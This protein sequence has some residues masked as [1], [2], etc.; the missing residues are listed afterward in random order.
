MGMFDY[1]QCKHKLS[2]KY[3]P[4]RWFQ[5]KDLDLTLAE[6]QISKEGR[7]LKM[8]TKH[9]TVPVKKRRYY[10]K[11]CREKDH[12]NRALLLLIGSVKVTKLG[13]ED[14]HYHGSIVFYTDSKN[15]KWMEYM[16]TFD[17]GQL[18]KI[19]SVAPRTMRKQQREEAAK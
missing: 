13:W 19:E 18:Q 10:K 7:L 12:P 6:Y 11:W 5:T 4:D 2:G 1:I 15:G 14:T 16:A 17:K 9:T 8:K 3:Y